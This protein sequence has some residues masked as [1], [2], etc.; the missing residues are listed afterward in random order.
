M[1]L[2]SEEG[3]GGERA[4][5]PVDGVT[6]DCGKKGSSEVGEADSESG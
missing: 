3:H 5:V 4:S 6:L 2:G 1:I